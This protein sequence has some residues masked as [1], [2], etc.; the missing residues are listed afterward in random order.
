VADPDTL[1]GLLERLS[2]AELADIARTGSRHAERLAHSASSAD[3]AWAG[4]FAY[5]ATSADVALL[6]RS[7]G[8]KV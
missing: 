3:R 1:A 2:D 7:T 6:R 5:L 4:V 8:A